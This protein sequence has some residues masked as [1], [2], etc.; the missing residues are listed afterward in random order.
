MAKARESGEG[1]HHVPRG[2]CC[3]SPWRRRMPGEFI[4]PFAPGQAPGVM[5]KVRLFVGQGGGAEDGDSAADERAD[6]RSLGVEEH[7]NFRA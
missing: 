3:G 1:E 6:G 2:G 5:G 4:F 7:G